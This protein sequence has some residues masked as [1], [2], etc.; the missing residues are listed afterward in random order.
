MT[1]SGDF[2]G[3]LDELPEEDVEGIYGS[4]AEDEDA[5]VALFA[6]Q[7][8]FDPWHL[9]V[10]QMVR[11]QQW[12]ALTSRLIKELGFPPVLQYF[13]LPGRDLFDV[14][15]LADVCS[16]HGIKIEY[17]GFDVGI[18]NFDDPDVQE[19]PESNPRATATTA[20][21]ALRQAGR[22]TD[23]A[24][25]LPDR[26]EDIAMA[27]SHASEQLSRKAPFDI[28]NMD[29]CDHLAYKPRG[30]E[31]NTFDALRALLSH[32]M[33]SKRPWLLFITTRVAPDL[34]GDPG[35]EF[36]RA[37][38]SNLK[39]SPDG[40]GSALASAIGAQLEVVSSALATAWGS[41]DTDFLKLYSI[42]VGKFLLQ[43]FHAQPNHP[44][45]VELASAYAY[46]VHAVDPDMLALAFR[47]T[48]EQKRVYEP[49]VGGA[50]VIPNLE[51]ERAIQVCS[52][53]QRLWDLDLALQESTLLESV[54]TRTEALMRSANYDIGEWKQFVETHSRR[55]L[56]PGPSTAPG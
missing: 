27:R 10:K 18:S 28:V 16:P 25:I 45:K 38:I 55:L 14:R 2:L 23:N 53:A 39:L 7:R 13:T 54:M 51:P 32:Q 4:A 5:P 21:S 50:A 12:A 56:T 17:F 35:I 49:V 11:D 8:S 6:T 26:L 40:F 37:V 41:H 9:P 42:G 46:R 43:F 52:K 29:A 31:R 19:Q 47:I 3:Q 44:A 24:V 30:R 22:I 33:D 15:V 48:P 36:Q 34:L 20:E 1:Y